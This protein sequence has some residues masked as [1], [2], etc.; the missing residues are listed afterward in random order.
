MPERGRDAQEGMID[1]SQASRQH[2]T[3]L[4][5][6]RTDQEPDAKRDSL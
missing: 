6:S 5:V 4:E 3:L 2:G 1:V